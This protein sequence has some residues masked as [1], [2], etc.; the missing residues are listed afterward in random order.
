MKMG[1]G[2]SKTKIIVKKIIFAGILFIFETFIPVI[3]GFELIISLFLN[4]FILT[5]FSLFGLKDLAEF[6]YNSWV[7]L[8]IIGAVFIVL[9]HFLYHIIIDGIFNIGLFIE[10]NIEIFAVFI[11]FTLPANKNNNIDDII[12][13]YA[14]YIFLA[15]AGLYALMLA[16]YFTVKY[17][18]KKKLAEKDIS[19]VI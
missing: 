5:C 16:I 13:P 18:K 19:N 3:T 17:I 1:T 7:I 15:A 12:M 2:N 6:G 9:L 10:M 4:Y 8:A 11:F 14:K